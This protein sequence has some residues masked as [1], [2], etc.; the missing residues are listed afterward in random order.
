MVVLWFKKLFFLI[1]KHTPSKEK[2]KPFAKKKN[3]KTSPT[4]KKK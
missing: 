1:E 3:S 4:K 2:K